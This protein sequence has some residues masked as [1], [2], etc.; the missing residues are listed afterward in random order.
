[1]KYG[2]YTIEYG[3]AGY[4]HYYL[5]DDPEDDRRGVGRSVDALKKEIDLLEEEQGWR[6]YKREPELNPER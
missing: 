1:M 6:D 3:G 5:T 2:D 4:Y